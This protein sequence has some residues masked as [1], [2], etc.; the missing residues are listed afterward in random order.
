MLNWSQAVLLA[1]H[2]MALLAIEQGE[3]LTVEQMAGILDVSAD[4]LAKVA[5]D[6]QEGIFEVQTNTVT[7]VTGTA[8][9][10]LA[11]FVRA[12]LPQFK[13]EESVPL[14]V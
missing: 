12:H 5:I 11:E 14:G 7:E 3:T 10:G 4:H 8:P 13:G 6:H 1:F 9:Q 2:A